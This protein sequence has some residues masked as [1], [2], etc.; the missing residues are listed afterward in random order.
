MKAIPLH[1]NVIIRRKTVEEMAKPS[2]ILHM[3]DSA[4]EKA[5]EGVVVAVGPGRVSDIWTEEDG[6]FRYPHCPCYVEPG[7]VVLFGKFAGSEIGIDGE[8]YLVMR[9]SEILLILERA[10]ASAG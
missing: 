8:T 6:E 2:Q 3:P 1:D 7:D 4:V 10:G 5:Q 9:E